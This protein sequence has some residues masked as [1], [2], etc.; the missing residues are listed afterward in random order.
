MV[1]KKILSGYAGLLKSFA[2]FLA[3]MAVC[4]GVGFLV[5]FPLWKLAVSEPGAYTVIFA[6]AFGCLSFALAAKRMVLSYQRDRRRF[7]ISLARKMTILAGIATSVYLV[8]AWHRLAALAAFLAAAALYGYL[9][10]ATGP[11]AK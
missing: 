5:V 11:K 3:L 2:M 10:F 9:A 7:F 6:L 1:I 4:L 8:L